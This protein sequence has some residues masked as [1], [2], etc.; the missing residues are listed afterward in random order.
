MAFT[1]GPLALSL[2]RLLFFF[3]FGVALLVGWLMGR[4]Q[5]IPVEPVLTRM[6]L[7]GFVSARLAFVFMYLED[8]LRHPLSIIDIRDGGFFYEVGIAVAVAVGAFHAWRQQRLRKPLGAA[9]T[10]GFLVWGV[11]AGSLG[12]MQAV[13]PQISDLPLTD[14]NGE[15]APLEDLRGKPMVVNLWATWCG[16]CRAEMPIF[17]EAQQREDEIEFVFINQGEHS[18]TVQDYLREEDLSLRNV[19]L[20]FRSAS[21]PQLGAQALPT[22]FFFDAEG[23][24]VDSHLGALSSASLKQRLKQFER[25]D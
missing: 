5:R 9:I 10:A 18:G 24:L 4:R 21:M 3:A 20:D 13:Q 2:D 11:T 7:T 25:G 23:V 6:L 14:L 19:L 1:A 16:P 15:P 12:L 22:T 17:A 8:Y